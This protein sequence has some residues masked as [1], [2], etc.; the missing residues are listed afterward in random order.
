MFS[1]FW[2]IWLALLRFCILMSVDDCLSQ[3]TIIRVLDLSDTDS[4]SSLDNASSA[5]KPEACAKVKG[6][7]SQPMN[8][9]VEQSE[10]VMF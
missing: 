4:D 6:H 10:R 5:P 3:V 8:R 7:L 9:V 2:L 1:Y